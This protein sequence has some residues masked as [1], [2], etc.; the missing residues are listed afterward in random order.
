M[1]STTG[2]ITIQFDN[3]GPM[4]TAA[5]GTIR[6]DTLAVC[7]DTNNGWAFLWNWNRLGDGPHTVAVFDNGVQFDAA[8]FTVQT[9]GAEFRD[10]ITK[11]VTIL[12]FP[13]PGQTATLLWQEGQQ[14][15]VIRSVTGGGPT[16]GVC[17]TKSQVVEEFDRRATLQ[18]TNPCQENKLLLHIAAD[19][20]NPTSFLVCDVSV[21]V[22]QGGVQ[23]TPPDIAL[24]VDATGADLC[25]EIAPGA[26]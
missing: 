2:T 19:S 22:V 23:F 5:Y 13:A 12:N 4:Y 21:V 25:D 15:F 3:S 8:T 24:T 9:L 14:N 26:P 1:E 18:V 10:D 17:T 11:E 16:G 6:E 7:G 20:T